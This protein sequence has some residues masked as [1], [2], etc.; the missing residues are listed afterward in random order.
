MSERE[1]IRDYSIPTEIYDLELP[2]KI[3]EKVKADMP[4]LEENTILG[5]DIV[6][7]MSVYQKVEF[8]QYPL[9]MEQKGPQPRREEEK[10]KLLYQFLT[11]G[12]GALLVSWLRGE[13]KLSVEEIAEFIMR[14][15][16]AAVQSVSGFG[17]ER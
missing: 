2:K 12:C 14:I 3:L 17:E 15:S 11:R 5:L 6:F 4:A 10:A 8:Y 13:A 9:S 1:I 16:G 7:D